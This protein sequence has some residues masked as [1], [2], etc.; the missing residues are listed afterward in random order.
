[1]NYYQPP[2]KQPQHSHTR[3][4]THK[5]H[6]YH[7][8]A[9]SAP[10]EDGGVTGE[11]QMYS[12]FT[13]TAS[14]PTV[15]HIYLSK[16]IGAPENY[17]DLLFN[18]HIAD[19]EDTFVF[20]LNSPG[21]RLDTGIQLLNAIRTTAATVVTVL[22]SEVASM[23]TLIFLAGDQQIVLPDTSLM[24]HDFRT[25]LIGTGTNLKSQLDSM[26]I[27]V[28]QLAHNVCYPFFS[29]EEIDEILS[30]ADIWLN[31]DEIHERF[32]LAE[33]RIKRDMAE[34]K[35]A[36]TLAARREREALKA[37]TNSSSN[38]KAKRNKEAASAPVAEAST[39]EE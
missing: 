17:I 36:A 13:N 2:R 18:M 14:G 20:H 38:T 1:M 26:V 21:G 37:A 7:K 23:A 9:A 3:Q 35:K 5:Q 8:L 25:G 29:R 16:L 12:V 10:S 19:E 22:E 15:N 11:E 27:R 24:F 30:G 39:T 33:E 31:H 4:P 32:A 6:P 34:A 28:N